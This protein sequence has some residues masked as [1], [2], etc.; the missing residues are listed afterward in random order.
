MAEDRE[1][2]FFI[3]L[4]K[5]RKEEN[6]MSEVK[7]WKDLHVS[8]EEY[9]ATLRDS[10]NSFY[11]HQTNTPGVSQE[12]AISTTSEMAEN[13]EEAMEEFDA[14]AENDSGEMDND[15]GIDME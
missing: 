11:E 9:E 2:R 12:E 7:D 13:Y 14:Q 1:N 10:V 4:E 3:R 8:R 15:D 5:Y 6:K